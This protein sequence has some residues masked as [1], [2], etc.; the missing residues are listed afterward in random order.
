MKW[1]AL[2]FV[3]LLPGYLVGGADIG[4][5]PAEN[6]GP[7]AILIGI[8][9]WLLKVELPRILKQ[10]RA[11][12]FRMQSNHREDI[13]LMH[14]EFRRESKDQVERYEREISKRDAQLERLT[15][16]IRTVSE[17]VAELHPHPP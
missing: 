9:I 6:I 2:A 17:R 14:A 10:Y 15:D 5:V 7:G 16:A 13:R 11:D 12:V 4:G 1:L 8:G 3:L